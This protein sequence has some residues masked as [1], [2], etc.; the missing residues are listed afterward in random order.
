MYSRKLPIG[1]L[2]SLFHLWKEKNIKLNPGKIKFNQEKVSYVEHDLSGQGLKAYLR[3]KRQFGI[4]YDH[5]CDQNSLFH[6]NNKL[7]S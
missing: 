2:Q 4:G 1:K 5:G 3:T 6:V 7:P